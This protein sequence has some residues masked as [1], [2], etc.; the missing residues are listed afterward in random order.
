AKLWQELLTKR[1]IDAKIADFPEIHGMQGAR[2]FYYD[3]TKNWWSRFGTPSQMPTGEPGGPDS[4]MFWDFGKHLK[5]HENSPYSASACHIN[6]QC[7]RFIEIGNNVFMEYIK[8]KNG[9]EKLSQK[10]VDFGG[11]LERLKAAFDDNPDVFFIDIF[12]KPREILEQL[13]ERKYGKDPKDTRAFRIILDHMRAS[14][15]LIADGVQPSNVERGYVLRRLLRR[16]AR[17]AYL[18][19]LKLGWYEPIVQAFIDYYVKIYPE[20]NKIE[21]IRMTISNELE[22]FKKALE[23]GIKEFEKIAQNRI[24]SGKEAFDLYQSYGFPIEMVEELA[25]ERGMIIN[26]EEFKEE[27]KHHQEIS[28]LGQN[29]KFGGHGL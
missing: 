27:L 16:A 14:V 9:F 24:I 6:C 13:S 4:E 25:K 26:K 11:G 22:K 1:G 23:K 10:N 29:Q 20:L 28:R 5:I 19:K 3:E 7:G 21:E 8:T 12:K 15:F 17:Y 18:L 2:I